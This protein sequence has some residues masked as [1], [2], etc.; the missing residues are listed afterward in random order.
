MI[1]FE[2]SII[3]PVLN[4]EENIATLI[5]LL[6]ERSYGISA[7][8]IVVDGG[9]SDRTMEISLSKNATVISSAKGR[10]MQMNKG[11]ERASGKILWFLHAD[12]IPPVHYDKF[13]L[14]AVQSGYLSGCFR[15]QFQTSNLLLRF[16]GWL[17]RFNSEYCRGGDQSLFVT[18]DVFDKSGKYNEQYLIFEDNEIL[19]R[20]KKLCKFKV[21]QHTLFTSI[22]RY[23]DNG[24]YRLQY[25]FMR[26]HTMY[27]RGATI[28]ELL[29][30]YKKH[31]K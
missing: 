10:P 15:M 5:D 7:E 29:V 17:T 3:I 16:F 28:D 13:I 12:S 31:V 26:L 22:R 2:L 30:Y 6:H 11:A 1:L 21:I 18:A 20:I 23:R 8:I 14:E 19:P 27:R 24:I 9:S 4:E 25:R